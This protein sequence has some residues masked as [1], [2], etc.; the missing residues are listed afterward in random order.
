LDCSMEMGKSRGSR[1]KV[2]PSP[3]SAKQGPVPGISSRKEYLRAYMREYMRK[4]RAKP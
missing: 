4:R 1:R 2:V 3:R